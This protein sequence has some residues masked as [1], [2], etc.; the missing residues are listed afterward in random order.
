[1]Q[2]T[3][4]ADTLIRRAQ[5]HGLL[6]TVV[7]SEPGAA[8]LRVSGP[9]RLFRKT[10]RYGHALGSLLPALAD[11][12]R[13]D[14]IATL[15][16]GEREVELRLRNGDPIV[17]V[18]RASRGGRALDL[19][20]LLDGD[21]W[22]AV[23]DAGPIEIGARLL[24][25]HVELV[26]RRDSRCRWLIERVGFWTP[27]FLE[28]KRDAYGEAGIARLILCVDERL[29]CAEGEIPRGMNVV[30]HRGRVPVEEIWRIINA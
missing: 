8:C 9:L 12:E 5:R 20:K 19:A 13:F 29:Q 26:S 2:L 22:L 11:C 3:G 23:P 6:W 1:M 18:A 15:V 14:L 7:C 28:E 24:F 21:D 10:T 16:L 25:P 17:P 27:E 4:R 30:R